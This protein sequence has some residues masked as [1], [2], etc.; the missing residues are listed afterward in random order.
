[1]SFI[2]YIIT[3]FTEFAQKAE[4]N[5][6][7]NPWIFCILFFGSAIPLYYGYYRIARSALTIKNKKIKRKELD[8]N[9]LRIGIIIAVLA[10]MLPYV[11]M[12]YFGKLPMNYWLIFIGFV[13]LMAIFFVKTLK[14]KISEAKKE[15]SE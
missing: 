8:R 6:N 4:Q 11:Y 2:N 14:D 10:W 7:V 13:L 9:E 5:Y 1:M 3:Y 12:A 15:V